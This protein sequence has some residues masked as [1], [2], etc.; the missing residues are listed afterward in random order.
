M[1]TNDKCVDIYESHGSPV[2]NPVH[3]A[4]RQQSLYKPVLKCYFKS[5][6]FDCYEWETIASNI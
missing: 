3:N 6:C 2:R 5:L 4:I 1:A